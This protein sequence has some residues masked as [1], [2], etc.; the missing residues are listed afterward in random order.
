MNTTTQETPV[1]K[2]RMDAKT[3]D[4]YYAGW[5]ES[6]SECRANGIPALSF[7]KY[8]EQKIL[9]NELFNK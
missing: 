5:E 9:W 4:S 2:F 6:S 1:S 3:I 7:Y 8:I